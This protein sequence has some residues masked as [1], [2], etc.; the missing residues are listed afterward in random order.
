MEIHLVIDPKAGRVPGMN[1]PTKFAAPRATSSRLGLIE[2]PYLAPLCLAAT[3]LSRNPMTDIILL[4]SDP[5][6]TK[7]INEPRTQPS[8]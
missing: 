6:T 3:I 5:G 2:Y 1:D 4:Y 7:V 8:M